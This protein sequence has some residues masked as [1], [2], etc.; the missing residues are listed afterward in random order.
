VTLTTPAFSYPRWDE[1]KYLSWYSG[2]FSSVYVATNPFLKVPEF[3][4]NSPGEWVSNEVLNLA[5]KRG[6]GCGASWQEM[7]KLCGFPSTA[8]INRALRMTGSKRIEQKLACVSDTE[9]LMTIC[10]EQKIFAP[11]EGYFSPLTELSIGHFLQ[12]LGY[13]EVVVS[14][15][16]GTSPKLMKTELFLR[17]EVLAT[18]EIYA[19]DK[20]VYLSIYTDYHYFLVCQTESSR[21]VANPSD[22]FEGFFADDGTNDLWGVGDFR[23]KST[24]R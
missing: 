23:E 6:E 3:P 18:P 8:H 9:K 7:A 5:K 10:R 22:Y 11:D 4:L 13:E 20:S 15:H 12:K 16:F 2:S 17:P 21:S 19:N 1:D 14:D 24:G